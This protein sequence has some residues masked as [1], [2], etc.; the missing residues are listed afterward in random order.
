MRM[1]SKVSIVTMVGAGALLLCALAAI[2]AFRAQVANAS[3]RPPHGD[4]GPYVE[5]ALVNTTV[6][7][8]EYLRFGALFHGLPCLEHN[9]SDKNQCDS[10]DEFPDIDYEYEVRDSSDEFTDKCEL[11]GYADG[12]IPR[13]LSGSYRHWKTYGS[14]SH[15]ISSD[16]EPGPYKIRLTLTHSSCSEDNAQCTDSKT[17]HV[18]VSPPTATPTNT[19]QPAPPPRPQ[20]PPPPPPPTATPTATPTEAPTATP[21]ATPTEAPTA[22]PT[23]TP[24]EAPTAT[25]TATPTEAPTATPTATPTEAPTATPTATPTEA[26]TATPTA[27]PTEAPTATPNRDTDRNAFR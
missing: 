24:T 22:T 15:R 23:A 26:P 6:A 5:V 21:T 11:S 9:I 8:G 25:P 2:I 4:H 3:I 27:T 19:R 20:P 12:I 13:T 16:C 1:R 14:V 7:P 10:L 17:F 18:S